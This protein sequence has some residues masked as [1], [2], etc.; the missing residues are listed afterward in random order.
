MKITCVKETQ[1]NVQLSMMLCP[2]P[3]LI[4]DSPAELG[5]KKVLS[6]SFERTF[7]LERI[8]KISFNISTEKSR[9]KQSV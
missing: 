3:C 1:S 5:C 9:A 7:S 8:Y 4:R 2:V 6:P